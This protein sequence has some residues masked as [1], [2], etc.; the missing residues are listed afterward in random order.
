[1]EER[2]TGVLALISQTTHP[3][4]V[5]RPVIGAGLAAGNHPIHNAVRAGAVHPAATTDRFPILLKKGVPLA[6]EL[7]SEQ[8]LFEG[9]I[10]FLG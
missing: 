2:D 1:M 9:G 10:E 5:H 4:H 3:F 8:I 6:V 7:V